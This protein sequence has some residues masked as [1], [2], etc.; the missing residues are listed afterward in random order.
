MTPRQLKHVAT[1]QPIRARVVADGCRDYIVE[2]LSEGGAGL[3]RHRRGEPMRFR[4][5]GQVHD[6]LNRCGVREAVIR[7]RVADDEATAGH[8][9]AHFHD[10][11][12]T[13]RR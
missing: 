10:L 1:R 9:G 2:V 13:S 6:V 4:S 5:L 8:L 7:Q 3:L 12:L 11:P